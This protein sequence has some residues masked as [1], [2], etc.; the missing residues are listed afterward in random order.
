MSTGGSSGTSRP[1]GSATSAS[2]SGTAQA[3][4]GACSGSSASWNRSL[5]CS[6]ENL[7]QTLEVLDNS[8]KP[9]SPGFPGLTARSPCS[10]RNLFRTSRG[11]LLSQSPAARSPD[12]GSSGGDHAGADADRRRR[13]RVRY[14]R[15]LDR[16]ASTVSAVTVASSCA[17]VRTL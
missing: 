15:L 7:C 5:E 11:H 8:R 13:R 3:G 17:F 9:K 6:S 1:V 12:A 14:S 2:M 16:T 10:A 4:S